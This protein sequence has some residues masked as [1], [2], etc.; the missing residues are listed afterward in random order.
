MQTEPS[1]IG[2]DGIDFER[3][4]TPVTGAIILGLL[5]LAYLLVF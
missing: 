3:R 1:T 5:L 4:G 2:D